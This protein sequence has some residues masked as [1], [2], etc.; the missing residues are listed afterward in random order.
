[1]ITNND[2]SLNIVKDGLIAWYD[3][4][5]QTSY[6]GAGTTLYDISGDEND[7]SL[8]NGVGYSSA[9]GGALVLDG[10]ND[11]ITLPSSLIPSTDDWTWSCWFNLDTIVGGG[12]LYGQYIAQ[13]GNGRFLIEFEGVSGSNLHKL[14]IRLLS[15][16]GYGS[17]ILYSTLVPTAGQSYN[18][19]ISRNGNTYTIYIDGVFNVSDTT[20]FTA[21]LLQTTPI[22]GGRG[23]SSSSPTPANTGFIDGKICNT[24]IYDRALSANQVAYNY[25]IQKQRYN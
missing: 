23:N 22:I 5:F 18:A 21:S 3:A 16:S 17:Y 7:G 4:R 8:I 6:S 15:G 25:N 24:Y 19:A 20:S 14:N 9:Y 12:V 1:M 2:P 10:A 13:A 11:N